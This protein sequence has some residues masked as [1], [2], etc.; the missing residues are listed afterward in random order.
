MH[1]SYP[2]RMYRFEEFLSQPN[3]YLFVINENLSICCLLNC[4]LFVL[5]YLR[6]N[7]HGRMLHQAGRGMMQQLYVNTSNILALHDEI[8]LKITTIRAM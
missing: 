3:G 4:C 7:I 1:V 8:N 6:V 5:N 2:A